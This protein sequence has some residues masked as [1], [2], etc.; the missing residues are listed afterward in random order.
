MTK[1]LLHSKNVSYYCIMKMKKCGCCHEEKSV[2]RFN[3]DSRASDGFLW[4]CKSCRVNRVVQRAKFLTEKSPQFR[5]KRNIYRKKWASLHKSEIATK[6]RKYKKQ[7]SL[8]VL[9]RNLVS[10]AIRA[11]RITRLP[12]EICGGASE[13]HHD[14]YFKPLEVRWL[15]KKH[16]NELH[17]S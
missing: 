16:H 6:M 4:E 10:R 1:T 3:K 7:N 17:A 12:C 8:K 15:C 5:A 11:G 2:S 14:D 9:A 13:A